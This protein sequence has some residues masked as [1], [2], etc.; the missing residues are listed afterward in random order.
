MGNFVKKWSTGK[1]ATCCCCCRLY[2]LLL[3]RLLLQDHVLIQAE[4]LDGNVVKLKPPLTFTFDDAS[5]LLTALDN[6]FS[7]LC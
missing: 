4:G 6:S 1:F 5:K 3:L 7:E 2:L